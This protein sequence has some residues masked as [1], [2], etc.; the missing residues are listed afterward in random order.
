MRR[1][2]SP[3]WQA[4]AGTDRRAGVA[5][6]IASE[7][8]VAGAPA[9]EP[10]RDSLLDAAGELLV[11][12]GLAGLTFDAVAGR[13]RV[14]RRSIERRWPTEEALALDVLRHE[15]LVLAGHIR[16]GAFEFGLE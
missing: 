6:R 15:W 3:I 9:H 13:A 10:G 11:T 1:C 4:P 2:S 7:T 16:R 5:R 12:D 14:C 8:R